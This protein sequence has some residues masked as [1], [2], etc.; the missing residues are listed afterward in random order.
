M[1]DESQKKE[2]EVRKLKEDSIVKEKNYKLMK[3]ENSQ[4]QTEINSLK[5]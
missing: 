5:D 2:Q 1:E 4:F 3:A